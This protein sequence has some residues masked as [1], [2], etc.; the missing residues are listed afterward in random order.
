MAVLL[1][2]SN[3]PTPFYVRWQA[4]IGFSPSMLTFL[5]SAYIVGLL[6]SLA[7]TGGLVVRLGS[8]S[9]LLPGCILSM[10]A[11]ALFIAARSE[12]V[13]ILARLLSGLGV[14]MGITAGIPW[15]VELGG[16]RWAAVSLP[17]AS[18]AVAAGAGLGPLLAGALSLVIGRP[19]Q[20]AFGCELALLSTA[21]MVVALRVG[22]G[23][24]RVRGA[25]SSRLLPRVNPSEVPHLIRAIA[26][27]G[28]AL[29]ATAFL[30]SLGPLVLKVAAGVDDPLMAGTMA[31]S[32]FL[33]GAAVQIP[34]RHMTARGL[35]LVAGA[36]ILLASTGIA[37]SVLL[38]SPYPLLVGALLA[39]AGYGLAQLAGLRL[40]SKQ[41][42]DWRR[43][44]ANALLNIGAYIPCGLLPVLT[45]L[46][47]DGYG[48]AA[49]TLF[50]AALIMAVTIAV[51]AIVWSGVP[52][53]A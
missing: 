35:S 39:G 2:L 36:A 25:V 12:W 33:S 38:G 10:G 40:I 3:M 34:G 8:R 22:G 45:G 52:S 27:F 17:L 30:L 49:G 48:L 47:V 7:F 9:I 37:M 24:P 14:G 31:S 21:T 18:G 23:G 16:R 4:A 11:C 13:L 53:A 42:E 20:T 41:I 50:F 43:P 6:A 5:F 29:G 28:C 15:I 46:A 26:G 1:G 51:T 32:M 44:E 19:I